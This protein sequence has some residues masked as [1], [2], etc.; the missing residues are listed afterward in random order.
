MKQKKQR[1]VDAN[2]LTL[3]E[4]LKEL[5]HRILII[6]ITLLVLF[7][8][9]L[10]KSS[11]ILEIVL[12][13][14]R[15]AGYTMVALSPQETL[16]QQLRVSLVCGILLSVPVLLYEVTLFVLPA[17]D[18]KIISTV[19]LYITFGV[20]LFILGMCFTIYLLFPFVLQYMS[21]LAHTSNIVLN[22]SV[23]NYISFFLTLLL[24]IGFVF[25]IPMVSLF[26]S[27]IG[28]ITSA[29]MRKRRDI[30]IVLTLV[31]AA[32]I[33]PPDVVSQIMVAIPMLVLYEIS[34][35]LCTIVEKNKI[36]EESDA[37]RSE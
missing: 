9:C 29:T 6:V 28:L 3:S 23:E 36:K 13:N 19:Y 8:I 35:V 27:R 22:I 16:M 5:K 31:I 1:N 2:S 18:K 10:F 24:C 17:L 14:G 32:L 12:Q 26:L 7:F 33:T 21:T 34:I 37:L 15:D 30:V 20:L 25:E 11:S 4:H